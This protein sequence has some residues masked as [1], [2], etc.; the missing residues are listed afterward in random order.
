M[1]LLIIRLLAAH[2]R[3]SLP[4]ANRAAGQRKIRQGKQVKPCVSRVNSFCAACLWDKQLRQSDDPAYL[5]EVRQ[6]IDT[7]KDGDTAPYLVYLFTRAYERPT[8]EASLCLRELRSMSPS[9]RKSFGS[10]W[11]LLK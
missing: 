10:G 7:R 6:I 2:D 4:K 9:G 8:G 3:W 5:A 11:A 1:R